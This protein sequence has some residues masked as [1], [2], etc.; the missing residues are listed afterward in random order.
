[1]VV[2]LKDTSAPAI[3]IAAPA[4][5]SGEAVRLTGTVR[6]EVKVSSLTVVRPDG[7]GRMMVQTGSE[8]DPSRFVVDINETIPLTDGT[9]EITIKA[10][11]PAGN[12]AEKTLTVESVRPSNPQVTLTATADNETVGVSGRVDGGVTRVTLESV[13]ETTGERLDVVRAHQSS[14][15]VT[16]VEV[17]ES[18]AAANGTTVVR[19]LVTDADGRQHE[20]TVTATRPESNVTAA[21]EQSD[22]ELEGNTTTVNEQSEVKPETTKSDT[23]P[24]TASNESVT[25]VEGEREGESEGENKSEGIVGSLRQAPTKIAESVRQGLS[26][27][28]GSLL[29]TSGKKAGDVRE[30]VPGFTAPLT[31]V[32]L[33]VLVVGL[34]RRAG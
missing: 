32:G 20:T 22:A 12:V 2:V 6:D 26:D 25:A 3:T 19:A 4:Q 28:A 29:Q 17:N 13:D 24:E 30:R 31:V 34:R 33:G 21:G 16:H 23:T 15:P 11:D 8:P 14:V 18:L 7:T 27:V 1:M 5:T 10:S 9:N